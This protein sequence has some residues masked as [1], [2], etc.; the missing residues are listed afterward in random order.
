M[1]GSEKAQWKEDGS[2]TKM[3]FA[4]QFMKAIEASD[5]LRTAVAVFARPH[6][7]RM[8]RTAIAVVTVLH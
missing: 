1:Y 3:Y 7:M 2:S 4:M 6:H 5:I 8:V